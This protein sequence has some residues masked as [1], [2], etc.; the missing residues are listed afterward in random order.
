[1]LLFKLAVKNLL[2]AGKRTWLNVTV[3]SISFVIMVFYN[4]M[5]DGWNREAMEDTKLWEIGGGELWSRGYDPYDPYTF[6]E[7]RSKIPYFARS[8]AKNGEAAPVLITPGTLYPGGRVVNIIIKGIDLRQSFLALPTDKLKSFTYNNHDDFIP[9]IIGRRV[10]QS[11]KLKEGER[12]LLRWRDANGTFDAAEVEIVSIFNSNVPSVDVG[13]IWIPI[14][15]LWEMSSSHEEASYIVLKDPLLNTPQEDEW[16]YK[17]SDFLLEEIKVI[18]K[19][20]RASS[21]IISFI[22]LSIALLALFDTQV[23]SVFRRQKEIGTYIALGMTRKSVVTLF[24][25]EGAVHS[26]FALLFAVFWGYPLLLWFSKNGIPMPSAADQAGIA[27]A[28]KITPYYGLTLIF[29]SIAIV[30]I[31]SLIVSYLPSRKIAGMNPTQALK[32]KLI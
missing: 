12:V 10:S 16:N 14:E 15:K 30:L 32:G 8:L 24:T 4:G 26:I 13:Q 3:L 11:L 25:L 5:L 6:S 23:L 18:I 28:E 31:S 1:M 22:L 2:G 7:S 20:K 29:L 19:T 17:S 21:N 27:I 9:A